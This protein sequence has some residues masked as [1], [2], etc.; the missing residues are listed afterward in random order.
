MDYDVDYS[1][2]HAISMRAL[3]LLF[4]GGAVGAFVVFA[5]FVFP[6]SNLVRAEV[7]EE[8]TVI[9]KSN[10]VCIVEGSDS[11]PRTIEDCSYSLGDVVVI[12]YKEGTVPILTHA[13]AN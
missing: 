5:V 8:A 4:A 3:V 13:T 9:I 12:S 7:T 2:E 11:R 10:S 6:I 1:D